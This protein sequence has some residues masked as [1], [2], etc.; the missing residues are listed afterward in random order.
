MVKEELEDEIVREML[1]EDGEAEEEISD[2]MEEEMC[3][4]WGK[5]DA[6][7]PLIQEG[8]IRN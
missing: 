7:G 5:S 6:V 2:W 4:S 3:V 8:P 1:D